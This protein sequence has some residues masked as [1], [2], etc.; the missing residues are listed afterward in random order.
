MLILYLSCFNHQA[1]GQFHQ[2]PLQVLQPGALGLFMGI[3]RFESNL[4]QIINETNYADSAFNLWIRDVTP[5]NG[6]T[7]SG[8]VFFNSEFIMID[9]E[10]YL[11][12]MFFY[13]DH[14]E[15]ADVYHSFKMI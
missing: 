15:G 12:L 9:A 6:Q 8:A 11:Q 7:E 5:V 14:D 1:D 3:V 13:F 4:H 10:V 2:Y